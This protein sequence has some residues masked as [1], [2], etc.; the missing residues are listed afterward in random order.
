MSTGS[1]DLR[2]YAAR[3]YWL[4]TSS[5]D[6]T[7]GTAW[8]KLSLNSGSNFIEYAPS[9]LDAEWR[10]FECNQNN[11]GLSKGRDKIVLGFRTSDDAL[12]SHTIYGIR[13]NFRYTVANPWPLT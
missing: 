13:L 6:F 2:M 9:S 8:N 11:A 5:G 3:H 1:R 10:T 4:L 7:P 12:R